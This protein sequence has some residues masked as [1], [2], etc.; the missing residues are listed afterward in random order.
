MLNKIYIILFFIVLSTAVNA[1]IRI[2]NNVDVTLFPESLRLNLQFHEWE[3]G[4]LNVTQPPYN[5]KG[6]GITDDT[7][8]IQQAIDDAFACNL[9]V[10]FPA[11][12]YL[13]SSQLACI[14][15][16]GPNLPNSPIPEF[17]QRKFGHI[18]LG[19]EKNGAWPTLK[20]QDHSTVKDNV[21]MLFQYM[22]MDGKHD[23]SRHY[24]ASI[25]NFN[26]E[27]GD[28]PDVSALSNDGAQ[29]CVIENIKITG[30]FNI[31][32]SALPGSG[33]YAANI[34][35]IGGKI[36]IHQ[37]NYRPNPTVFGLYLEGQTVNAIKITESRGAVTFSGFKIVGP[38]ATETF[39]KA[40]DLYNNKSGVIEQGA[41]ANLNLTDGSIET[42]NDSPAITSYKQDVVVKDVFFKCQQITQCGTY[43]S[44]PKKLD[45]NKNKWLQLPEY[46][47]STSAGKGAVFIDQQNKRTG[48]QD[49]E[50]HSALIEDQPPLDLLSRHSWGKMPSWEDDILDITTYG[51]TRDDNSNNDAI[52]IQQ[53]VDAIAD[54]QHSDYNKILFIPRG[55]FHI[56]SPIVI[57]K[58]VKVIG[59]G[60][61][62]SLIMVDESWKPTSA[63][64]AL[65]TEN[66]SSS[67]IVLSDFGLVGYDP[68][69]ELIAHKYITLGVEIRWNAPP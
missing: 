25:R 18:L 56:K 29:H 20:L 42:F 59:A 37:K 54:P 63:V 3:K 9:L 2:Y 1:K 36:G 67:G 68:I 53:A 61:N 39:Y 5:A 48:G 23:A 22:G 47:Y 26:I 38:P 35:I 13:V 69:P 65:S 50:S 66:C 28:N 34:S 60:K 21:F 32:I 45:G 10:F 15:P 33:G 24:L 44:V 30:N 27:M 6:D 4:F 62:I 31:G 55:H 14:Q 52:A 12:T 43:S 58:G 41:R 40:I 16:A 7:Q 64:S 51:A 19:S 17:G 46:V 11:H 57:K 49:H 8:A